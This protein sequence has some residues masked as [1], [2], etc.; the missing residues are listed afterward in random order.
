MFIIVILAEARQLLLHRLRYDA[1]HDS[2]SR[3]LAALVALPLRLAELV[4]VLALQETR[5]AVQY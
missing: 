1:E 2:E 3:I 4:R 5:A